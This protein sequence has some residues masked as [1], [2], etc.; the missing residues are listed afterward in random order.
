M[1]ET[2]KRV[3]MKAYMS[4]SNVVD[5]RVACANL[6]ILK[7][8]RAKDEWVLVIGNRGGHSRCWGSSEHYNT[9]QHS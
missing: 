1:S 2:L 8:L 5:A 6:A 4:R 7:D 9:G 3:F